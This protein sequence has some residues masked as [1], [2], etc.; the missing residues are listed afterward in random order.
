MLIVVNKIAGPGGDPRMLEGFKHAVPAMKQFS[1]FLGLEIW[2]AEDGSM[3]G[4]SRW[5]SKEALNEY[6]NHPLFKSHHSGT[7]THETGSGG[8]GGNYY[9]S[10]T[11]G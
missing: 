1:G 6:L 5:A 4:V 2:T 7:S 9:T 10:E 3:Q 11:I 8:Q